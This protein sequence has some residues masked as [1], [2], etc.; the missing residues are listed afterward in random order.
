MAGTRRVFVFK[1]SKGHITEK[2]F[3]LGTRIDDYDETTCI[4][5][6]GAQEVRPA[7][8]ISVD[9]CAGAEMKKRE[10]KNP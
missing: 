9:F 3:M 8:V 2:F 4:E 1:C 5:C 6:L 10:R 7:Y